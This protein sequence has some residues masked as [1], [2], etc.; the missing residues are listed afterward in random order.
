LRILFQAVPPLDWMIWGFFFFLTS[1]FLSSLYILDIRSI[2]CGVAKNPFTF[3]RLTPCLNNA[4]F[5]FIE[6][7]QFHDVQFINY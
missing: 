6:V 4:V 1:S 3:Y 2:L 7:F 5:C